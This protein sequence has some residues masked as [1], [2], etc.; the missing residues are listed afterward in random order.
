MSQKMITLLN[1]KVFFKNSEK[2]RSISLIY[3][4]RK[5]Q[6]N[7]IE[8]ALSIINQLKNSQMR[9]NT[10]LKSI[11]ISDTSSQKHQLKK[12]FP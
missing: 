4:S 3:F 9:T 6:K 5:S 2:I 12:Q 10:L 8:S 1:F 11:A 7:N